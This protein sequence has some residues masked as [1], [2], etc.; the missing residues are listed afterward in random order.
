MTIKCKAQF[1]VSYRNNNNQ[2]IYQSIFVIGVGIQK[3]KQREQI[4]KLKQIKS[5]LL[6]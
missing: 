4:V 2:Q 3:R 1:K 5:D 6:L